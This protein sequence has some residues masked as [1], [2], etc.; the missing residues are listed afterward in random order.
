V[1]RQ[2]GVLRARRRGAPVVPSGGKSKFADKSTFTPRYGSRNL[3]PPWVR[4]STMESLGTF[5]RAMD[6][7]GSSCAGTKRPKGVNA[8]RGRDAGVATRLG[9]PRRSEDGLV[10]R[11][12]GHRHPSRDRRGLEDRSARLIAGLAWIV[13]DVG[14]T[15]DL[16]RDALVAALEQWP[17]SG[18][19]QNP[20]AWLMATAERASR[21]RGSLARFA[22]G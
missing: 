21:L 1:N 2:S 12:D 18:V 3:L 17:G 13:R 22:P 4:A 20:G 16:A 10:G 19:P 11:R 8:A 9:L 5:N 15:E 6:G 7:P 14:P